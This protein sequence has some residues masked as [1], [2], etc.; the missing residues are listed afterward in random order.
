MKQW[1]VER[2]KELAEERATETA[3]MEEQTRLMQEL[4]PF[5]VAILVVTPVGV[6]LVRDQRKARTRGGVLSLVYWKLPG[7]KGEFGETPEQAAARELRQ[8]TG[9]DISEKKLFFV[10]VENRIS[11]DYIVFRADPE[12]APVLIETGDE[13]E[14]VRIFSPQEVL[15]M[16]DILPSHR[17]IIEQN[18]SSLVAWPVSP[19]SSKVNGAAISLPHF[20]FSYLRRLLFFASNMSFFASSRFL[21]FFELVVCLFIQPFLFA[22]VKAYQ[23]P[24]GKKTVF[25]GSRPAG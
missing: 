1:L 24:Q 4:R 25:R 7:G 15:R 20:I 2:E 13:G 9:I 19:S 12:E 18:L 22:I 5:A 8:E 23:K 10:S 21:V 16:R 3:A 14:E 17:G 6:P 11:H